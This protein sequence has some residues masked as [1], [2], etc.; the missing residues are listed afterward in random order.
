[1]Q[2]RPSLTT[3]EIWQSL[4]EACCA[5]HASGEMTTDTFRGKL[6]RLG[7]RGQAIEAEVRLHAPRPRPARSSRVEQHDTK[8]ETSTALLP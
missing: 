3:T 4:Y 1:M 2:P 5:S 6:F 8:G 7:F